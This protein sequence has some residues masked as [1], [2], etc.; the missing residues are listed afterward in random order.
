L[1][2][3]TPGAYTVAANM[4]SG[5]GQSY[6]PAQSSQSVSVGGGA[7][8]VSALVTY[9]PSGAS[10]TVSVAGLPPGVSASISVT[11]PMGYDQLVTA[12]T[13]LAGLAAGTY[14]VTAQTVS[15]AGGAQYDP[16]SPSTQAVNLAAGASGSASVSYTS[17]ASPGL[18]LRI[19]GMYLTQSV[20]TYGGGVPLVKDRDGF[21]RVF[22]TA[23]Q[24][25]IAAP[26]VRVQFFSNGTLVST[27]TIPA[28]ALSV[29]LSPNE[30]NLSSSWNI[31]V[32]KALI[33]PNLSILAVVD[34]TNV[35][36]ETN[37]GDNGFPSPTAPLALDVR[38]T[39]AFSVRFVPIHQVNGLQGNVTDAN[40][41]SFLA[42]AMS[43]HPL[44]GYDADLHAPLST[45][46]PAVDANN[47]NNAWTDILAELDLLR[48]AEGTSRYY[49]GVIDPS[50]NGGIAGV[51]Y[52]GRPTALGW[53]KGSNDL[54]AAHE[55]GHNWGRKHA[56]CGTASDPDKSYPYAGGTIGVYGFDV[57]AQVLKPPSNADLMGYCNNE[58]ISDYTYKAVLNYRSAQ[59]DVATSFAQAMQPCLLVS[60][61]IVDGQPVLEPAF[62]I[63][64]RPSLPASTG[65]YQVE[66]RA[67]DGSRLFGVSF[68]P[69]QVADDPR[70]G[71]YFAFALPLQPDRAARLDAIRLTAPGRPPVSLRAAPA[72]ARAAPDVRIVRLAPDRVSLRWDAAAHPMLLIRDP[73]TG[74]VLSFAR[75][76]QAEVTTG[77]GD[78][79]VQLSNGVAGRSVRVPVPR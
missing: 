13:T 9:G 43:L 10:L 79:D 23:S 41:D 44:A 27:S 25:N 69:A 15:P 19:D 37:E 30:G 56:P 63:V 3:L 4:V 18:N 32:P 58:W 53:D 55:W 64:T 26:D 42:A 48:V 60:G 71:E 59:P 28:P 54:V 46:R 67:L 57:A 62:Q 5:G 38:T 17:A 31:P 20:Q 49:Y 12:T 36:P 1:S 16:S 50:Y 76:G 47:A 40:K 8:P 14:T 73:A 78:L 68:T 11:G 77:R 65:P 52:V 75:G 61:R 6:Q 74:Q 35:V 51:G 70:G 72:A 7:T 24:S 39:S 22:V 34:P 29:P 45:T 2:G 21:L 66:G 33:Q